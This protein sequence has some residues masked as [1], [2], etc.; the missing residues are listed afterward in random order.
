MTKHAD[1]F[2]TNAGFSVASY[3]AGQA[4]VDLLGY[5]MS[6]EVRDDFLY[7][8]GT[9]W[10]FRHPYPADLLQTAQKESGMHLYWL[11]DQFLNG[12]EVYDYGVSG[13]ISEQNGNGYTNQITL[14]RHASGILPIDVMIRFVDESVRWIHIPVD[15]AY[16]HKPVPANWTV[17]SAWQWVHPVYQ[18]T[19]ESDSEIKNVRIDPL[20]RTPDHDR[21]NNEFTR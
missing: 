21:A 6:D 15:V 19:V 13:V 18:L 10:R 4:F 9:E 5:V 14:E 8:L 12:P 20:G 17:E 3:T 7:R 2:D 1:W 16:G 11:F